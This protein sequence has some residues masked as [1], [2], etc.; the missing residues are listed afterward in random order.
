MAGSD[1]HIGVEST[2]V[3]CHFK[4]TQKGAML[5]MIQ[6]GLVSSRDL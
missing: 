3:V 6:A 1:G 2:K 5:L 4:G